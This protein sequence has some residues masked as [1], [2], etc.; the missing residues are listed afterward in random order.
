M[1]VFAVFAL[2][3]RLFPVSSALIFQVLSCSPNGHEKECETGL[4]VSPSDQEFEPMDI[5]RKLGILIFLGVPAIVGGGIFYAAFES[6]TPVFI[7]ETLLLLIA[8]G[9]FSK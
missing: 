2:Q 8:G 1:D 3:N 7:F 6:Y 5:S 4:N 9:F